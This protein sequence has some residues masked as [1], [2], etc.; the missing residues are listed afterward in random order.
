MAA[1]AKALAQPERYGVI[2][3]PDMDDAVLAC[4][5]FG[6]PDY[7]GEVLAMLS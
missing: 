7:A 1:C 2:L 3:F 5:M 6:H 4:G